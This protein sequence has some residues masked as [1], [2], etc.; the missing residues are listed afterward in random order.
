MVSKNNNIFL[1]IHSVKTNYKWTYL[2]VSL[3]KFLQEQAKTSKLGDTLV[4]LEKENNKA[5]SLLFSMIPQE[6]AVRL[7][8]GETAVNI[9]EVQT[10]FSLELFDQVRVL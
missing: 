7:K 3:N 4:E 5:D 8:Q 2:R 9:A 10:K 6:I 1:F